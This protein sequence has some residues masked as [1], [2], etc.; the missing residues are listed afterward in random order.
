MDLVEQDGRDARQFGVVLEPARQHSLGEHLHA[1]RRAD[2]PLVTGLVA[3]EAADGAVGQ[4]GHPPG[5]GARR[6]A[7]RFEHDDAAVA[8]PGLVEQG[9]RHERGLAGSGG[10]AD[11]GA[12]A[13]PEHVPERGDHCVYVRKIDLTRRVS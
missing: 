6:Q 9:E 13:G 3:D 2:A 11:H 8:A 1:R 7:A 4:L 5:R 12:G 10:R